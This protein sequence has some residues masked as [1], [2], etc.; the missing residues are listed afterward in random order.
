MQDNNEDLIHIRLVLSGNKDAFR[1]IINKYK[2]SI[3]NLLFKMTGNKHDAEDLSQETFIKVYQNLNKY[4][5]NYNVKNWIFTIASNLCKNK[6]KRDKIIR[7]IPILKRKSNVRD[8]EEQN[9]PDKS[10]NNPEEILIE[11]EERQKLLRVIEILPEKYKIVF[12]LRYIEE[13][14]YNEI[15]EITGLP[16]GTV[17]TYLFRAKQYLLKNFSK[18]EIL[19]ND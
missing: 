1:H 18:N 13:F 3:Y 12:L 6:I 5:E 11:K 19:N 10:I 4:K 2:D 17:E 15:V 8:E 14:S 9:L 16:K 7:F